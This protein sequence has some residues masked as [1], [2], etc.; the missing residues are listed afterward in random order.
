MTTAAEADSRS[1]GLG[2]CF[3]LALYAVM[4]PSLLVAAVRARSLADDRAVVITGLVLCVGAAAWPRTRRAV[5]HAFAR[6]RLLRGVDALLW[7]LALLLAIGEVALAVAGRFVASPLL[8]TPNARSQERIEESRRQILESFGRDA[9]N[10]RGHNDREPLADASGVVRI[11][12]L[13]DS[14]AYGVVGYEAN[15]LTLLEAQLDERTG[16]PVEVVNLGLPNLQPK[17]YLQMLVDDGPAAASRSGARVPLRRQRL[18][19]ARQPVAPRRAQLALR[20]VRDAALRVCRAISARSRRSPSA[21]YAGRDVAE[22]A[23]AAPKGWV[24]PPEVFSEPAYLKVATDYVARRA[25]RAGRRDRTPR[26][27]PRSRSSARS[28]RAR[29]RRPSRSP[30]CRASCR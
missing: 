23:G 10:A 7:N 25:S 17:D 4:L 19:A 26:W 11:V 20:R 24:P 12:A 1:T 16:R 13:G 30:C 9:G 15:F 3:R 8:V 28:P 27:T 5:A 21:R 18:Q 6:S 29:R 2:V 22:A 14:F